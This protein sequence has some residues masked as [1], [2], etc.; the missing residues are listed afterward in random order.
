METLGH[1]HCQHP[2][3][4]PP[5]SLPPALAMQSSRQ[6]GKA[7]AKRSPGVPSPYFPPVFHQK[8]E[9]TFQ[10][11]GHSLPFSRPKVVP[12][13]HVPGGARRK[14]ACWIT[15]TSTDVCSGCSEISLLLQPW[16]YHSYQSAALNDYLFFLGQ[17]PIWTSGNHTIF[18]WGG[19]KEKKNNKKEEN[20]NHFHCH[21][22]QSVF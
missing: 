17:K 20:A 3:I 14:E 7:G 11:L 4:S 22:M 1:H 10:Q 15:L 6:E 13:H 8:K 16:F 5:S 18:W 2:S 9:D 19:E 21:L 12:G